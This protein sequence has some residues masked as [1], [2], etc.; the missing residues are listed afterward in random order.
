MSLIFECPTCGCMRKTSTTAIEKCPACQQR[1]S[2]EDDDGGDS[3]SW[4]TLR[5]G[6]S[7]DFEAMFDTLIDE[8]VIDEIVGRSEIAR[9]KALASHART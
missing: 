2:A 1:M 9:H 4:A 7:Y 8:I 3:D 5:S 6:H